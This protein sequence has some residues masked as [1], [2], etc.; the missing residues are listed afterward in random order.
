ME[1]AART[2]SRLKRTLLNAKVTLLFYVL[3]LV[4]NFVARKYF[5]EYLGSDFVGLT[6]TLLNILGYLNLAELGVSS[7]VAF[8][9][10]KP[11]HEDNREK[12]SE[13]ISLLG[14]YYRN[15]GLFIG[16]LGAVF[17]VFLFL[18]FKD[19]GFDNMLVVYLTFYSFLISSLLGYFVNYK[20]I[21]LVADQRNY[22]V[23][24]L[25]QSSVILKNIVQ[26]I[27][28]YTL[29]NMYLWIGIELLFSVL[30][31]C[32][33]NGR[34]RQIYPWLVSRPSVGS[35]VREKYKSIL[36][37]TKQV[38]IHKFKDFLL[39]QSDQLFVFLFVSLQM[40]AFYGNY[41]IITNQTTKFIASL[42][43]S[44]VASVGN[45]I[46]SGDKKRMLSVFWELMLLRYIFAAF[47]CFMLF[48][49]ID[50]LITVWLGEKYILSNVIVY[51]LLINLFIMISRG[52]V[53]NY[54]FAFG[55][56]SDVWSAWV[57]LAINLSVTI[58]GGLL[59]G[60]PGILLGKTVSLIPIVVFWKP[61]YLFRDGLGVSYRK[62]W[63]GT[64]KYYFAVAVSFA[65]GVW[66]CRMIPMAPGESWINF[67]Y[68]TMLYA[69][70]FLVVAV[71][72]FLVFC[73]GSRDLIVRFKT[74][75]QR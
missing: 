10:Y 47:V 56:F 16:G 15:I 45:L 60:I 13:I 35:K 55:H 4:V 62:Y 51:L 36:H 34:I 27:V 65:V 54:N 31:S 28:V 74:K 72:L 25:F 52:T 3:T 63:G 18:I 32:V 69:V 11:L 43:D 44:V 6:G 57:E 75:L 38:F 21:L 41:L 46:A 37:S 58:V 33:L 8:N 42:M 30:Y 40:V 14:Y 22:I 64:I 12:I 50:P 29:Q 5:L 67:A 68:C 66:I 70:I 26:I 24:S 19:S 59:W 20:Q 48:L 9:L 53:D 71:P 61:L 1:T 7:A 17:S 49:L 2:K 73:P 23:N 39:M